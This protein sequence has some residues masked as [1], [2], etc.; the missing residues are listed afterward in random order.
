MSYKV[1]AA[2][3]ARRATPKVSLGRAEAAR[4]EFLYMKLYMDD[5]NI[6][7]QSCREKIAL[8]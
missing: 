6:D 1:A 4:R 3:V 7:V 5:Y 8:F 2:T